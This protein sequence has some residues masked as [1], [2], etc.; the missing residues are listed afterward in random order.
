[1]V[2]IHGTHPVGRAEKARRTKRVQRQIDSALCDVPAYVT[3]RI[4]SSPYKEPAMTK[5]GA[6]QKLWCATQKELDVHIARW[7][8]NDGRPYNTVVTEDF[9]NLIHRATGNLDGTI[10]SAKTY[11][12]ILEALF[13]RFC[14]FVEQLLKDEFA[15]AFYLPFLNLLH[16]SCTTGS[17]KKGIV[18]TSACYID[19][20]WRFRNMALLVTVYN[21]SHASV[22]VKSLTTSRIETLYGLD[23]EPMVQFTMSDTTPS[24]RKISKLF[25]DSIPT[26]CSMHVLNL[27]LLYGLGPKLGMRENTETVYALDAETQTPKK[28]RRV[29]TVGGPFPRGAAL[30]K[31]I[32]ALNNYFN[33]PQRV[34][35][36]TETQ[37]Y[38]GLPELSTIV[39]CDT[40][41]ASTVSLFQ[42]TIINYAAFKAYFEQC[43]T[44]DDPQVFRKLDF[45]D[46]RLLVE[47]EAVTESL[48]ELARIE[49]QRSN[50]V[51]S[52]LIVLLK[53]AIDRLG[54]DSYNIYDMDALRSPK[55]N[56]KTLPRR[57][58]HLSA[59]S[60]EGQ[61]CV[62]RIK[63]QVEKRLP[64]LT[65][66]SVAILL[67][68]PR[69][70]FTV[71]SLV[72][73]GCSR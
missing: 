2:A 24:A 13:A 41:V 5:R 42:R 26:D 17:G 62:A 39:D 8:I 73:P 44:Y 35:R 63:G 9:R 37:R 28:E 69:T 70:K 61:I 12:I 30:I 46:W 16:D 60:A 23:I 22:K 56:E 67:L 3:Q 31:K 52:E 6:L 11:N 7:L 19:K 45:A 15:A 25:E 14:G 65:A 1:M 47:M 71:E 29:C 4:T 20:F 58:I 10:L 32:R 57:S 27:C 64:T 33:R 68:D 49:V 51:A 72:R 43:A 38:Y 34:N 53:F 50:Q 59:L 54:A 21:S 55:T 66:E 40:R 36:L 18:G 48:A